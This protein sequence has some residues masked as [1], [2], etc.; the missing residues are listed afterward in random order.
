MEII[1]NRN[2]ALRI[3]QGDFQGNILKYQEINVIQ[4]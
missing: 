1:N 2:I 4:K 3:K